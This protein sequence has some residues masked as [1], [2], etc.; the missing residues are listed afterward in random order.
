MAITSAAK[1]LMPVTLPPGPGEAGDKT[2]PDWVLGNAEDDWDR[3]CCIFR[4]ERSLQAGWRG[5]QG[6]L[7]ADQISHQGRKAIILAFKVVILDRHVL[8]FDIASFV[9]AFAE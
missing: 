6:Y 7:S 3:C 8:A 9:E 2:K 4:R 5:D 1:K